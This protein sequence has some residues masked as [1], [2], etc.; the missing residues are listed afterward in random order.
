MFMSSVRLLP[1]TFMNESGRAVAAFASFYKI[2][3]PE[4]LVVHDEL[5]LPPGGVKLK[6]GGGTSG[7]NGLNNIAERLGSKDFWRLRI[8]IGHPRD[9]VGGSQDVIDYVLH[10]P[11]ADEQ[12]LIDAAVRRS[13]DVWPLLAVGDEQSA[14]LKLHTKPVKD[15]S[16]E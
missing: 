6:F 4:I 13:L 16:E 3:A 7:H 9:T 8:G 5:D 2:S 12:P 14:M 10:P 15:Q 1:D 11:R